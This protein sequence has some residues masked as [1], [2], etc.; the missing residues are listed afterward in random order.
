MIALL[1]L[2]RAVPLRWWLYLAAAVAMGIIL[3]REHRAVHRAKQLTEEKAIAIAERDQARATIETMKVDAALN[4]ETTYA[5][6]ERLAEINRSR[7]PISVLCRPATPV[8]PAKGRSAGGAD[9]ATERG[10]AE[11][12]L[13]DIGAALEDVRIEAQRN[14]ARFLT[15]QEWEAARSH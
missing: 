10:S 1:K 9:A 15:L 8:V 11:T 3:M 6:A 4:K 5:L 12:P 13:R 7:A 14:N 2:L